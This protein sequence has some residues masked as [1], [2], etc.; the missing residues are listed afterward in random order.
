MDRGSYLV[1]PEP[2]SSERRVWQRPKLRRALHF[3]IV[4][5]ALA[6]LAHFGALPRL[7]LL[8]AAAALL[9]ALAAVV[10][11]FAEAKRL[12]VVRRLDWSNPLD[13]IVHFTAGR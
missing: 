7:A 3:M 13:T 5:A 11:R 6:T 12:V 4:S 1:P 2:R 8:L 10:L 9:A